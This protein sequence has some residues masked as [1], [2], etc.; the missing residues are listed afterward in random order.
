MR[1]EHAVTWVLNPL[2]H[3]QTVDRYRSEIEDAIYVVD[4]LDGAVKLAL[5][6]QKAQPAAVMQEI[7]RL[8]K[9]RVSQLQS[10]QP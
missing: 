5:Q 1:V 10:S 6:L 8:L 3:S 7:V 2:S 4:A 9:A